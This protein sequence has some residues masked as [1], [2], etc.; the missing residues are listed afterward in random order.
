MGPSGWL[1]WGWRRGRQQFLKGRGFP[2]SLFSR[3]REVTYSLVSIPPW[4][5]REEVCRASL[6]SLVSFLVSSAKSEGPSVQG[7]MPTL[8]IGLLHLRISGGGMI[9]LWKFLRQEPLCIFLLEIP[10]QQGRA[11]HLEDMV[12]MEIMRVRLLSSLIKITYI[13]HRGADASLYIIIPVCLA[14]GP[15]LLCSS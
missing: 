3:D 14:Q 9:L 1:E 7:E 2:P 13:M 15:I 12:T 11:S 5:V 8:Q 6:C 4:I 10:H